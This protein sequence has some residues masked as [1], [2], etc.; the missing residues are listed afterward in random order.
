MLLSQRPPLLLHPPPRRP[1]LSL[2][3]PNLLPL[4]QRPLP[5]LSNLPPLPQR[6]LPPPQNLQPLP[7][8]PPSTS[9]RRCAPKSLL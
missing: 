4:P 7:R 9:S 1:S 6:P 3:L 5:P 8:R 2:L